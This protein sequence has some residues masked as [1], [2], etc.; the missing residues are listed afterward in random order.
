[1]P[2]PWSKTFNGSPLPPGSSSSSVAWHA[3]SCQPGWHL[4]LQ[5]HTPASFIWIFCTS[6]TGSTPCSLNTHGHPCL[7]VLPFTI[8]APPPLTWRP[9]GRSNSCKKLRPRPSRPRHWLL[10][11]RP[12]SPHRLHCSLI[13]FQMFYSLSCLLFHPP[14]FSRYWRLLCTHHLALRTCELVLSLIFLPTSSIF[15]TK[16]PSPGDQQP[17]HTLVCL[18]QGAAQSQSWR[19]CWGPSTWLPTPPAS[20]A[21]FSSSYH[22]LQESN[23]MDLG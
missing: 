12:G 4:P 1:M 8:L 19:Y 15:P 5:T 13:N 20:S 22:W 21:A 18:P 17:N 11:V 10:P 6:Q 3:W 23:G 7:H 2:L 14:L 9:N 16:L